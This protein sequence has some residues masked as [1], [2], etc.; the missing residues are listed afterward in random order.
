MKG[1]TR[2]EMILK[3]VMAPHDTPESFR[4]KIPAVVAGFGHEWAAE[5]LGN[6]GEKNLTPRHPRIN[7]IVK[8][9]GFFSLWNFFLFFLWN[10]FLF[11]LVKFFPFFHCGIFSFFSLS[12]FFLFF[13]V[14]FFPFFL[15]KFFFFSCEI[16]SFFSCE[17]FSFFSCEIFFFFLWNLG[18]QARRSGGIFGLLPQP[19][20]VVVADPRPRR[21]V[22]HTGRWTG[23][24]QN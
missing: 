11:F 23:I 17:I 8:F 24:G 3:V 6:E 19:G 9:A 7:P 20:A 14:K 5:N 4:R 1:M 18:R 2:A 10:F 16:F 15:V 22:V 13:L 12:N 21:R